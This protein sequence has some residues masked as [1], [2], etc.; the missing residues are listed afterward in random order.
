MKL[1]RFYPWLPALGILWLIMM[2]PAILAP[3]PANFLF[4]VMAAGLFL[5]TIMISVQRRPCGHGLVT[6]DGIFQYPWVKRRCPK[7]GVKVW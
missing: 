7:C 2:V 6:M 5:L 1:Q 4:G 3:A